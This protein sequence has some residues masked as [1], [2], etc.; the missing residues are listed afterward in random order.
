MRLL[1][2]FGQ[3]P[4]AVQSSYL[5]LWYSIHAISEEECKVHRFVVMTIHT[6]CA[7][8]GKQIKIE[9]DSDAYETINQ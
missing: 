3:K 5:S 9:F 7:H 8:S 1:F 4:K 2:N 6:E